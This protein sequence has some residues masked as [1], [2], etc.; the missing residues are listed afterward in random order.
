M[1]DIFGAKPIEV[2]NMTCEW[3]VRDHIYPIIYSNN[4]SKFLP[5]KYVIWM[6]YW[7]QLTI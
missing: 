2:V 7:T 1:D 5:L 4:S 3:K 6:F